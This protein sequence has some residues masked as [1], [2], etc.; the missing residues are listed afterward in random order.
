VRIAAVAVA[1]VAAVAIGASVAA[2]AAKAVAGTAAAK[3]AANRPVPT[4]PVVI[5]VAA[6]GASRRVRV[7]KKAGAAS[8]V[9]VVAASRRGQVVRKGAAAIAIARDAASRRGQVVRKAAAATA[10]ARDV[11]SRC[12]A[13]AT[14]AGEQVRGRTIPGAKSAPSARATGAVGV[15]VAAVGGDVER[16]VRCWPSPWMRAPSR[17]LRKAPGRSSRRMGRAR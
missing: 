13:G 5:P 15:A 8:A 9:A 2:G 16:V 4:A 11:P 12:L 14:K 7:A 1:A 17:W 6:V 10:V 3:F